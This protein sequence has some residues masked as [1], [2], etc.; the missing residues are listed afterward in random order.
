MG[1]WSRGRSH[2]EGLV[3]QGALGF[4]LLLGGC[5]QDVPL[6]PDLGGCAGTTAEETFTFGEIPI[7]TCL[8]GPADLEFF[9]QDGTWL[10]VSNADP[11][12]NFV[13]GSVL[14]IPWD[15]VV[16]EIEAN[17]SSVP[18][19][20]RLDTLAAVS[21]VFDDD[22]DLDE[23]D[24]GGNPF[25]GGIGRHG[26]DESL[27]VAGRLTEGA[28]IRAG[29]DELFVIDT[30]GLPDSVEKRT[31]LFL[32]DDP[33]PVVYDPDADLTYV[34]NLTDHS[35]SLVELDEGEFVTRDAATEGGVGRP[36]SGDLDSS[37]SVFEVAF[38]EVT[39]RRELLNE[40]YDLTY[41]SGTRRLFVPVALDEEATGLL[42]YDSPDGVTY[43]PS[44]FGPEE[45]LVAS[46]DPDVATVG[47]LVVGAR[48]FVDVDPSG[49]LRLLSESP[50]GD[51]IEIRAS[52]GLGGEWSLPDTLVFAAEG[53]ELSGPS[54]VDLGLEQRV[55]FAVREGGASR[56]E[57]ASVVLAEGLGG[58]IREPAFQAVPDGINYA[59]PF[60]R[61]DGRV[62]RQR[63]W[64]TVE[65]AT[66]GVSTIAHTASI[67]G[68]TFDEPTTVL[69]ASTSVAAPTVTFVDGQY[70]VWF[71]RQTVDG[72]DL[73]HARSADGLAWSEPVT[74]LEDVAGPGRPPRAAVLYSA[75]ATFR[76]EGASIGRIGEIA[77]GEGVRTALGGFGLTVV[78]GHEVSN[79]VAGAPLA[80]LG[81]LPVSVVEH[82]GR[83]LVFATTLNGPDPDDAAGVVPVG[84]RPGIEQD[85]GIAILEDLGGGRY[86]RLAGGAE[87][88][89]QLVDDVGRQAFSPVVTSDGDELVMIYALRGPQ[90]ISLRRATSSDGVSWSIDRA[91]GVV[92][93]VDAPGESDFDGIARIPHGIDVDA[94]SLQVRLWYTA[95]DGSTCTIGRMRASSVRDRFVRDRA[96]PI[97]DPETVG[98]FD[99]EG[100]KDPAPVEVDG[101]TL[102]LY[103]GLLDG[104]WTLGIARQGAPDQWAAWVDDDES[105]APQPAIATLPGTFA[106]FGVESPVPF[107][108]PDG[109]EFLYAGYDGLARRVGRGVLSVIDGRPG[110]FPALRLA[111]AGDRIRFRTSRPP[112]RPGSPSTVIELAQT[113]EEFATDGE[114][115]TSLT[116]DSERGFLY[117]TSKTST[118]GVSDRITVVDVRDD[119]STGFPDTN[120]LDIEGVLE[121][122]LAFLTTGGFRDALVDPLRNVLYLTST[123][124]DGVA[125]VDLAPIVDDDD[126]ELVSVPAAGLLPLPSLSVDAGAS[127]T[128]T[129]IGGAGMA[130]TPDGRTLVVTHFRGNGVAMFDLDVG[131]FGELVAWI[132]NVGENPHV[133][134]I[135]PD[136]RYAVVANYV[137]EVEGNLA[138]STLAVLDVDPTSASF[139]EVVAWI[140]NR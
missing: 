41:I 34:G 57:S 75:A 36:V 138:S 140:V 37:G 48:P 14:V 40:T 6:G 29:D 59:D 30:S 71:A 70:Q 12:R 54:L 4:A 15:E 19:R 97:F 61:L 52:L 103:S 62:R 96:V 102:L 139:Q 84:C 92:E 47:E 89:A 91:D 126:K 101:E 7:G 135:A 88:Q 85:A 58:S 111:S 33:F 82:Q 22:D 81:L 95:D 108:G 49:E 42:R 80:K 38:T 129:F 120:F 63:M 68:V 99:S 132:P 116:L 1:W 117:V 5:I 133:V 45:G 53:E 87:L 109:T 21:A 137:G 26:V 11:Y 56:I 73:A 69:S 112:S 50:E 104:T 28:D 25:L 86:E 113:Q 136:G 17:T 24:V 107:S 44:G 64:L 76:I 134:K 94:Q 39:D 23:D 65:D 127:T 100:V 18:P 124:P 110:L 130:L 72:W 13:T 67:D 123:E 114:G 35:I 9:E 79:D 119:G 10:A 125:V 105:G 78:H 60:V 51:G 46:A 106:A 32:R 122:D 131:P 83:S 27:L 2:I 3:R 55:Y 98:A 74:V 115:M 121:V 90:R 66:T 20:I 128:R 16:Q 118:L 77:A 43:L 31:E 93:I 8:A